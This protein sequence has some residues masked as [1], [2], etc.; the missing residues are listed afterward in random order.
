MNAQ[1]QRSEKLVNR[2]WMKRLLLRCTIRVRTSVAR[3]GSHE[4]FRI[5]QPRAD[6]LGLCFF[7]PLEPGTEQKPDSLPN[8]ALLINRLSIEDSDH[9]TPPSLRFR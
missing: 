1:L 7:R 9:P 5:C 6:A 4:L 2:G 3:S 8:L